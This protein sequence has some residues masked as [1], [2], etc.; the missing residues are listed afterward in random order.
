[1]KVIK[2]D[3]MKSKRFSLNNILLLIF[4]IGLSACEG[5][6]DFPELVETGVT[7]D[8]ELIFLFPDET[9]NI[10]PRFLPNVD[11]QRNYTWE[12][13]DPNIAQLEM[14]EDKSVAVTA[15]SAGETTLRISSGD[16]SNLSAETRL[17]VFAAKPVDITNQGALIVTK[18]NSKGPDGN[19][20]SLKLVDGN[21]DTK[22]LA[23]FGQPFYMVLQF[24]EPKMINFY[25]LTS[26][27]DAPDRDPRDWVIQGT[28]DGVN[29]EIL[30]ERQDEKFT[31]RKLTREFYFENDKPYIGYL[32]AVRNNNGSGLFQMSEWRVMEI[33]N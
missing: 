5:R 13:D 10:S 14:M 4:I 15:K 29:W 20:G 18:E 22:Y 25:S 31:S 33:P 32:F 23:N 8:N 17:K 11:P 1:M 12:V 9:K 26:G 24:Q 16:G 30:D 3:T 7:I 2:R 6:R 19:E 21:I 28:N 27:N